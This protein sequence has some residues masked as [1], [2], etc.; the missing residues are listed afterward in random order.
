[1]RNMCLHSKLAIYIAPQA[2]DNLSLFERLLPVAAL[3]VL[4]RK[5]KC[6]IQ[7]VGIAEYMCMLIFAYVCQ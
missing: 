1:M 3:F 5:Y 2:R 6:I 7:Q 4:P